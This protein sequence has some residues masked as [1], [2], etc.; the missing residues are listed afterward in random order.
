MVQTEQMH[1]G[2]FCLNY[3]V[4]VH[5]P[6]S[7]AHSRLRPWVGVCGLWPGI[8]VGVF[9]VLSKGWNRNILVSNYGSDYLKAKRTCLHHQPGV[10][11]CSYLR[12]PLVCEQYLLFGLFS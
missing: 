8:S 2:R 5:I 1:I 11:Q 9:F 4:C 12:L 10:V 3:S 6:V 7:C